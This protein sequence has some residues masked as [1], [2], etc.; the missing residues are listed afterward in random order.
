MADVAEVEV[1]ATGAAD[2][3]GAGV[4]VVV[5]G[6]GRACAASAV[7]VSSA[8]VPVDAAGASA[9][10]APSALSATEL[11]WLAGAACGACEAA[12][13]DAAVPASVPASPP[14]P[15]PAS[16]MAAALQAMMGPKNGFTELCDPGNLNKFVSLGTRKNLLHACSKA[17]MSASGKWFIL[18][19]DEKKQ[20][21]THRQ[22]PAH[23]CR[24]CRNAIMITPETSPRILNERP[25]QRRAGAAHFRR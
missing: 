24:T 15:Q 1:L 5:G 16:R 23:P 9:C 12:L 25:S 4:V 8:G 10:C 17:S 13:E 11:V 2:V 6:R 22:M 20:C 3:V 18:L 21:L 7:A 19:I 14:P